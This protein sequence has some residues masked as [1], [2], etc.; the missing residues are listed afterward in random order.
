MT[1]E[2]REDLKGRSLSFTEIAKLVGENWQ[3]L[4]PS[5]KEPYEQQAFAAKEKYTIELAEYRKTESHRAYSEY[6]I[7]FKAKQLHLGGM[8]KADLIGPKLMT[9]PKKNYIEN[10][11]DLEEKCLDEEI[12]QQMQQDGKHR[13]SVEEDAGNSGFA[14]I[15]RFFL[16]TSSLYH[17]PTC[18][19]DLHGQDTDSLECGRQESEDRSIEDHKAPPPTDDSP[20]HRET[21]SSAISSPST[22]NE[23]SIELS[24]P[25]YRDSPSS[26][27]GQSTEI[28]EED[29][30]HDSDS[31]V[32]VPVKQALFDNLARQFWTFHNGLSASDWFDLWSQHKTWK[33]AASSS[34]G[35]QGSTRTASDPR[36]PSDGSPNATSLLPP[37]RKKIDDDDESNSN[38]NPSKR[39]NRTSTQR[40]GLNLACPFHKYKPWKYNHG[41][42]RFRTC[43]TTPFDAIFRLK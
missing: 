6:L 39:S 14:R 38:R 2:M 29:E 24:P 37:K 40:E 25:N 30:T 18:I 31:D 1:I 42:L 43:S 22:A 12:E 27:S 11:M 4:S 35:T 23:F 10:Y 26:A 17:V 34:Q 32:T 20:P 15:P 8:P 28:C 5:E 19:N 16:S 21:R 9:A 7:E 41:I 3:N 33:G 13:E 36:T